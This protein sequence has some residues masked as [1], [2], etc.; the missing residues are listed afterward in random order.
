MRSLWKKKKTNLFN[1][2]SFSFTIYWASVWPNTP[3]RSNILDRFSHHRII[4]KL[5]EYLEAKMK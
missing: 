3:Y 5:N 4:Q 1:F 2:F